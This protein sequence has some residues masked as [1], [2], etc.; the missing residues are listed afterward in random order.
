MFIYILISSFLAIISQIHAET[1]VMKEQPKKVALIFGASGQDG[2]YL[3][4]FL[5]SKGY[6]VHGVSRRNFNIQNNSPDPSKSMFWHTG[7]IS[8]SGTV[9]KL[10]QTIKPDEIY[11]LAAQSGVKASF[12]LPLETAEIN[13]V[14]TLHI[15]ESIKLLQSQKHI[16]FFQAASSELFGS[17]KEFPQNEKTGFHPL[18]PYGVSKLYSYWITINYREAYNIFG[19]NGI[20]FNHESPLRSESFITRKITLAACRYKLGLQNVLYLGNLDAK[21][22]WGYARD[23]VEAMWLILQ[24]DKPEDFVIATGEEHS[25]R[26]CV[27]IAYK[28]VGVVIEWHE[29][30]LNEYGIDIS[31]G[32]II[33]KIDPKFYRPCEVISSLGDGSKAQ[34]ILNWKPKTSFLE[35]I[36]IMV[37]ADYEIEKARL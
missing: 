25:V 21:R 36:K 13:A 8:D 34:K 7:N 5:L 9:I 31:T 29:Q 14:G 20:L 6:E 28:E 17:A 18:S 27:E 4:E 19:C 12:D 15:L 35:L 23:Y 16:K 22:D 37:W 2:N 10:V 11:N 30:G 3:S 32:Q 26:E 33:V 1:I 24:Q